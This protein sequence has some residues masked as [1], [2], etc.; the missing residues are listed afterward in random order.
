[1]N[2]KDVV[3]NY[4]I[5]LSQMG[6]LY[7]GL[8]PFH[9]DRNNPNLTIYPATNSWYCYGGACQTGGDV[10]SFIAKMEGIPRSAVKQRLSFS[11]FKDRLRSI[12]MNN[13]GNIDFKRETL[14]L[15]SRI[16]R[17]YLEMHPQN[18]AYVQTLLYKLDE[19]FNGTQTLAYSDGIRIIARFRQYLDIYKNSQSKETVC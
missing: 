5:E 1:M 6:T 4:G 19:K 12:K 10:I 17:E 16:C 15:T 3:E 9:D 14:L 7:R 11:L 18:L 2:I 13:E 8:C